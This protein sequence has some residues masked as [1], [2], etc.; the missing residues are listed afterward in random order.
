MQKFKSDNLHNEV[1]VVVK[2]YESREEEIYALVMDNA[3][4][5]ERTPPQKWREAQ[6]IYPIVR[7]WKEENTTANLPT[8]DRSTNPSNLTD[9]E[10]RET[11]ANIRRVVVII[12]HLLR[13]PPSDGEDLANC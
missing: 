2:K 3:N 1:P 6:S 7:A 10:N 13:Q 12:H 5:R 8:V 9:W 11:V 4:Q